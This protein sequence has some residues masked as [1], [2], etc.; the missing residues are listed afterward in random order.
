MV[1]IKKPGSAPSSKPESKPSA[2]QTAI[3]GALLAVPSSVKA[4]TDADHVEKTKS[5]A[6]PQAL[7]AAHAEAAAARAESAD[8]KQT[9]AA[10]QQQLADAIRVPIADIAWRAEDTRALDAVHLCEL[11]LSFAAH[12]QAQPITVDAA[13]R[14]IAG[15]HRLATVRLLGLSA[16]ERREILTGSSQNPAIV[17]DPVWIRIAN[18]PVTAR[19]LALLDSA[20]GAVYTPTD[21]IP[22]LIRDD[23]NVETDAKKALDLEVVENEHR[24]AYTPDEIVGLKERLERVG[25]YVF[26]SAGALAAGKKSGWL[27]LERITKLSR[28][29][30]WRAVKRQGSPTLRRANHA[31]VLAYVALATETSALNEIVTKAQARLDELRKT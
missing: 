3:A 13:K 28:M 20:V 5:A 21:R 2:T 12:G 26:Q 10:A 23:V 9:L 16:H 1:S 30:L 8:L 17:A 24:K 27:E 4:L 25:G 7:A 19:Q 31:Q 22:A 29:T 14:L 11:M 15:G 18:V 6:L